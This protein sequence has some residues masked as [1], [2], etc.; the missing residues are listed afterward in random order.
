M[1]MLQTIIQVLKD[2]EV[3]QSVTQVFFSLNS[4]L[5]AL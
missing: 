1:L 5:V 4:S 3:H 2:T